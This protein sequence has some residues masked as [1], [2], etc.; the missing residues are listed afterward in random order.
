M[1][2]WFRTLRTVSLFHKNRGGSKRSIVRQSHPGSVMKRVILTLALLLGANTVVGASD[3]DDG[4]EAYDHKDYATAVT[5]FKRAAEQGSTSA[6]YNL[7][8]AYD[9]AQGVAQDYP[10]AAHW[11][12]KAAEAGDTRAQYNLGLMYSYGHGVAQDYP[13]AAHWY[14]KAAEAGDTRA[15]YNLGLMYY[16]G[17]GV[18]QDFVLAHMWT[19]LAAV[20]NN[21]YVKAR[22]AVE[23][24]MTP[25]Q[26]AEAQRL[27]REWTPKTP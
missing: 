25:S 12:T 24:N 5:L 14:T 10:Q 4:V 6:Q 23:I 20:K 3:Y 7:G 1:R 8:V 15:Q 18:P 17:T 13:Q 16:S 9:Q 22:G 11:Y 21:N 19:N 26:I 2:T 27:A